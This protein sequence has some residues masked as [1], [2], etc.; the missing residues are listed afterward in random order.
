MN[1]SKP[2][3]PEGTKITRVPLYVGSFPPQFI[4][5]VKQPAIK[6]TALSRSLELKPPGIHAGEETRN[7]VQKLESMF[8][9]PQQSH[10]FY[11][12]QLFPSLSYLY[13]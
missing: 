7:R 8:I 4:A 2:S 9:L 6:P 5:K 11:V 12:T 13:L 1:N 3:Y 10:S